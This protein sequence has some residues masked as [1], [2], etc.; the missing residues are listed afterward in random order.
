[1]RDRVHHERCYRA[2][3]FRLCG[4]EEAFMTNFSAFLKQKH[5]TCVFLLE[6]SKLEEWR[7]H[8]SP[9]SVQ[10]F[11]CLGQALQCFHENLKGN[12]LSHSRG[13]KYAFWGGDAQLCVSLSCFKSKT[14]SF[15]LN[16]HKVFTKCL[17]V[18]LRSTDLFIF[19]KEWYP[20]PLFVDLFGL[21]FHDGNCATFAV[22]GSVLYFFYHWMVFHI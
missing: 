9:S 16:G 14:W 21:F 7:F 12:C 15:T 2:S 4:R 6:K 22:S 10:V 3:E 11:I 18:T 8:F 1:M 17:K 5:K 19:L 20:M 13:K